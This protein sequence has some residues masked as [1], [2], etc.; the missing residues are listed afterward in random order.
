MAS[1]LNMVQ[2]QIPKLE[3]HNY[4]NWSI[5]MRVLLQ[6]QDL[7]DIVQDGYTEPASQEAEDV[8]TNNQKNSLKEARKRDKKALFNIYQGIDET[9]FE[10]VS[11]ATTSKQAWEILK[12]SY[13]GVD[14]AIRV[15]LQILR[16]EFESLTM[17]ETENITDYFTR[18][19]VIVNQMKRQGE[20]IE[21]VRVIEKILRSLTSKFEHVVA[22]IEESKDLDTMTIDQLQSSLEIHEQRMKKK[23][24]ASLEHALEAKMSFKEDKKFEPEPSR[25]GYNRGRGRGE[26]RAYRGRGGR[27]QNY[28][29][30]G[31]RQNFTYRGRGRGTYGQQG[32]GRGRGPQRGGYSQTYHQHG[33]DKRNV[34]CYNCH[35]FGHYSN[36][37]PGARNFG[38]SQH[39]NYAEGEGENE[40]VTS[41]SL[42]IHKGLEG[43]QCSKW[44]LDT[45]ASNHMCG[46]KELFVEL[47]ETSYGDVTFGDSSKVEVKGKGNILIKLKNGNHGFIYDVYYVPAMKSNILSLG[48]LLEKGFDISMKDSYLTIN[49]AR[50]NLVAHV[51]MSKN[52]LFA[53]NM[54]H[55]MMKCLKAIVKDESWLW[56]LRLG[57][58]NFGGLKLLSTKNMVKGL[59]HIDHPDEVCEGCILGKHHRPSF[60]K[61]IR[62][63]ASRL[64]EI[65]HTD[66]CGPLNPVSTGGNQ[67]FL[68]FIDDYSRKTWVYF[69]K[70]KS[71]VFEIFKE[72]KTLVERQS[73]CYIKV[74][75]SD[76]GGEFTSDLFENFCK[77]H[78][79]IHQLTP[80]YTPQL[81]GVAERKNRTILDMARSM[82]KGKDLPREFWAEAVATAVYLLNRCPTKSVRNMTPEEAWSSFKPSVAHLRVFGCIAYA[83]IPEAR[84]I[85]LDDKGVKC[86]F[87]GY[88]DRTMGYKLYNP[89]TKKV[90]ISRD[91]VFEEDQTWSWENKKTESKLELV[92]DKPEVAHEIEEPE[93][94]TSSSGPGGRQRRIR[95]L[96]D[97]YQATEVVDEAEEENTNL[98]CFYMDVDPVTY[99]DAAQDRKWKIAMDEEI[100]AIEKNDTWRLT[101]LPEGR[102]AI[103]VKWV[104]K[105]K[106]NANGEVQRY[107][108]RLVVKGFKQKAG[109]DYSEVFAPVA[110]LE[111]IRL[112]ISLAAQ[113]N[114]KIYQLDVKSAFLNGFLEEEIYVEQPEGYVKQGAEDKVYR[115]RKA[116]Y[117][118]K[119][120]PRA[121][122]SRI[123]EYFLKDGFV[124][125]PYEHA[126]YL[127]RDNTGNMLFVC[128]Y[129]D[130]LIFTGNCEA[131]FD[132]FKKSMVKEFEMTDI[133]LMAHFLGIEVVQSKDGIFISQSSFAKQIL[134]KFKMESCNPV[135]TPV[136]IGQELRKNDG[137]A[138]VDPTYFKSL[139]GSLRYLT[140]TRPDILYGVGLISRY[141]ETPTRTH[142][143]AAK[144]ILRYI[145]GTLNEGIFYPS[146]QEVKLIGYSDS[147]WG[148][149][150]D[151]RKSTTGYCFYIGDAVF[152]W[153]SK[154]QAIVTLST[155]EAEYVAA[156]STVCHSIWLRNLLSFLGFVQEGPTEIYVDNKSAIALAKNPVFH[157]RSKHIDTRYHFIREHVSKNDVELVYCKSQDQV[158]DIF[159]KPLKHDVF[160]KLKFI[161][162]M[163][164]LKN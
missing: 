52:R 124:K 157:E 133:G 28:Q 110:R 32:R 104:Y 160:R 144:R 99:A 151:E 121:W 8:L 48:Q 9:T 53:L 156:S 134:E 44:Y 98:I 43:D 57:H 94:P 161:L 31:G 97:I 70:R 58:L 102:K 84:R 19:L 3:K 39:V 10:R 2:P 105:T 141:M 65:V 90:I 16:G 78:G 120:A 40:Q 92:P 17:S 109:I 145:K 41:T 87:V 73:G 112:F 35:E 33:F 88:G 117:G 153:S 7:W 23:V 18:A 38:K 61:E 34:E 71:E 148:R 5:Q 49:D 42:F 129:V 26:G 56:H 60:S 67:Y 64:L 6:S 30:E 137:E 75:R 72:F 25:G 50:G 131:M 63:R 119:Q 108:A 164:S 22:A 86:I 51:K 140:C 93:S 85:K 91:V 163:K 20:K 47:N 62:W 162:G 55:D 79:I 95:N 152:T 135:N 21:D 76:Q 128:L 59:P 81:N 74:L 68:T 107:K 103:G 1:M 149:D 143:N 113:H 146:N 24:P 69:L 127:K 46:N 147:D 66:V 14:K 136:E 11:T 155:C 106:K 139:V 77:E 101:K 100:N 54:K 150:L 122:N 80:A 111:T 15:R 158:A 114:W 83:K 27:G 123:N 115:L 45:G 142:L 132:K 125:C 154:K 82:V 4:G 159:T 37:C 29:S 89:L 96:S 126:L 36:A 12:N 130:D 118:L 116:L 13:T 138:Q